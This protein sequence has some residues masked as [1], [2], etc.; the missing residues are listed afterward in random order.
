MA[1]EHNVGIL[2]SR[3]RITL[4]IICVGLVGYH[5]IFARILGLYA[6]IA[7]IVL[8]AYFLKTGI[9]RSCPIMKAMDVSTAGKE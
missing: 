5:F 7:V 2:D 9:T 6:L 3:I 1:A 8:I 4:G